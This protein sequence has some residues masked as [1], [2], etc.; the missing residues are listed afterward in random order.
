MSKVLLAS[1]E[2]ATG[3]ESVPSRFPF[4]S[5]TYEKLQY[6]LPISNWQSVNENVC[7]AE[8][9]TA[10]PTFRQPAKPSADGTVPMLATSIVVSWGTK[11]TQT[12]PDCAGRRESWYSLAKGT[13]TMLG[14]T[15]K[16][17][18]RGKTT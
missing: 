3:A 17:L 5:S 13:P 18:L 9:E 14:C 12:L 2:T 1:M 11:Y 7:N 16:L 6:V 10:S 8:L 15:A 4:V